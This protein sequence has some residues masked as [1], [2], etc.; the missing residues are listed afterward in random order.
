MVIP[1]L[2]FELT[3]KSIHGA[4][5]QRNRIT[6]VSWCAAPTC[7]SLA[8]IWRRRRWYFVDWA[9]PGVDSLDRARQCAYR[10]RRTGDELTMMEWPSTGVLV[11]WA[12]LT[13][14]SAVNI[15]AWIAVA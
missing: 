8:S 12:S 15:A 9:Q 10:V 1:S 2:L 11:W 4:S 7:N 3:E 13:T 14:L 5:L 6:S